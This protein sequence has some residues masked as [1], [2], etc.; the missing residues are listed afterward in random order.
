M[1]EGIANKQ[2]RTF[3]NKLDNEVSPSLPLVVLLEVIFLNFTLEE[4]LRQSKKRIE[5]YDKR[6]LK[7]NLRAQ[8]V[9]RWILFY[10]L[11]IMKIT[12]NLDF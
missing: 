7:R 1:Y 11:S 9:I 6:Y 5:Y 10:S 4:T 2:L 8:L 3:N 12:E